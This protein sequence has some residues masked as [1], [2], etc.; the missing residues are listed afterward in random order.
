MFTIPLG[1]YCYCPHFSDEETEAQRGS[2]VRQSDSES[3][4]STTMEAAL[5][6]PYAS[7][8][9]DSHSREEQG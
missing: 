4:P 9:L 1:S 2:G 3:A 8:F 6:G 5:C 7:F